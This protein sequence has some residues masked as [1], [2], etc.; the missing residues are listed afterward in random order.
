MGSTVVVSWIDWLRGVG[1]R[2]AF[3][4]SANFYLISM[5]GQRFVVAAEWFFPFIRAPFGFYEPDLGQ[6]WYWG[7]FNRWRQLQRGFSNFF[8]MEERA[9]KS[10]FSV[11]SD[12]INGEREQGATLELP[13]F[14]PVGLSFGTADTAREAD[15]RYPIVRFADGLALVR[16]L[17]GGSYDGRMHWWP[18]D[19]VE[20]AGVP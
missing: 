1:E 8:A 18:Q 5:A 11:L 14:E 16:R 13:T 10:F 17:P 2:P 19:G 6:P 15:R 4:I 20:L 7:E 9:A 12:L 3:D